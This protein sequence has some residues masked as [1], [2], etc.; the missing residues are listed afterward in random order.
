MNRVAVS[1]ILLAGIFVFGGGPGATD[2]MAQPAPPLKYL[3]YNILHGGVLS[4]W[5]GNDEALE[6]RFRLAVEELRRL[7]PDIIGV[8]E[9][10]VSQRRGNV[11]ERLG[12]ALGFHYVFAPALFRLFPFEFINRQVS[13]LM[14]F[15]EGPAILSRFPILDSEVHALPRCNG[16]I[17]PRVLLY[18]RVRTP[19]G[20]LGVASAHTSRGFCEA[21]RVIELMEARRGP[22]PSV[23]MGDFN[24]REDSPAI[25]RLVAAGLVDAFRVANPTDPGLTTWQRVHAPTSTVFGR[26]DYAFL[27]PGR[28]V[29]GRVVASRVVL[30]APR[31]LEDGTVL[32][33]SDHYGV[34]SELDVFGGGA[35]ART[36]EHDAGGD[37]SQTRPGPEP[38]QRPEP[39]EPRP[40][41]R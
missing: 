6:A 30:D 38:E 2:A 9:A 29:P 8:Q 7:G 5:T 20:D 17:D 13:W 32:W 1:V 37:E 25:R 26:V 16:F 21:E 3:S 11:A 27:L 22:L 23:L 10:S 28:E 14:N 41:D 35:P 19:W 34:L 12:R 39:G 24:A 18:A 4:G 40:A 36:E 33:P 15:Q 31:R